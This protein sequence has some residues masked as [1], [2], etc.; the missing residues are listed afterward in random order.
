VCG[1]SAECVAQLTGG[2]RGQQ[3]ALEQRALPRRPRLLRG[4]A[5]DL[6]DRALPITDQ[7]RILRLDKQLPPPDRLRRDGPAARF[8]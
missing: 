7:L 3:A 4:L 6:A 2:A 8:S 1:N 5:I